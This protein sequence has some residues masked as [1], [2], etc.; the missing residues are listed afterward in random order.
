MVE[1]EECHQRRRRERLELLFTSLEAQ[2]CWSGSFQQQAYRRPARGR[3][4]ALGSADGGSISLIR[5][6]RAPAP[7]TALGGPALALLLAAPGSGLLPLSTR[8]DTHRTQPASPASPAAPA[9]RRPRPLA[10]QPAS[11]PH[12]AP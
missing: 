11:S 5:R 9:R 12:R 1:R 10:L 2:P 3:R 6:A 7:R 8:A 4:W